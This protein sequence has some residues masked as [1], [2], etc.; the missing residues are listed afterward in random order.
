MPLLAIEFNLILKAAQRPVT[1]GCSKDDLL[2]GSLDS[3]ATL[4]TLVRHSVSSKVSDV[5]TVGTITTWSEWIDTQLTR[6]ID[7]YLCMALSQNATNRTFTS[8]AM[9][10]RQL[11]RHI[12]WGSMLS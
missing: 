4:E 12:N 2:L 1:C 9:T 6:A 3:L 11:T 5:V 8:S 7:K 10:L